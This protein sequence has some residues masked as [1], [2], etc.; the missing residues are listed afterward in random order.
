MKR[1]TETLAE[2]L[3]SA[4]L[5]Q[6]AGERTYGR[7]MDYYEGGLVRSLAEHEGTVTASVRGTQSYRVKLWAK[8][9]NLNYSCNCPVGADDTFCKHAVAVGLEWLAEDGKSKSRGKRPGR[10]ALTM[11]D[12]RAYLGSQEKA[13][14]IKLLLD[15]AMDDDRLLRQAVSDHAH[16]GDARSRDVRRRCLDLHQVP[17]PLA[18]TRLPADRRGAPGSRPPR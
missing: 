18:R 1:P 3:D 13:A 14:L 6:M 15:H 10:S 7:G 12:V 17:R 4:L 8:E 16:H 11:D 9:G 2:V 5:R